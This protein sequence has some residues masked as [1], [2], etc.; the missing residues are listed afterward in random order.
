MKIVTHTDRCIS[1]GM[2]ALAAP[3]VFDQDEADGRVVVLPAGREPGARPAA[4]HAAALCPAQAIEV[5][6]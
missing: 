3:E 6:E 2:C 5:C 1:S 4:L